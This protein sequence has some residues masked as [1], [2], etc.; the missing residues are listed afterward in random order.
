MRRDSKRLFQLMFV[1]V[2]FVNEFWQN[3]I[4]LSI[5]ISNVKLL[6]L[7]SKFEII[8]EKLELTNRR[9]L[10]TQRREIDRESIFKVPVAFFRDIN[11]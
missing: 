8:E 4:A 3:M 1:I 10:G 9:I 5:A 2:K 11:E 6:L 7:T